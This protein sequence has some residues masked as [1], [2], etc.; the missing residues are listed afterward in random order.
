MRV[1]FMGSADVSCTMLEALLR[2]PGI[3]VAGVV[4]QPDR[5][6]GRHRS[7]T[8]CPGKRLAVER[9]LPVITPEKVN[10]EESLAQLAAWVPEVIVVVAYGQFLGKRLLA[11]PPH[12]CVNIHLSLLPRHRGAAPVQWAIAS[13]DAVSGVT[14]MLM[15]RGMDSGDILAQIDAPIRPDDT[16]ETLYQRLAPLGADLLVRTLADLAVG[17][18]QRTPQ[19]PSRVTFA[20][21]LKKEDGRINWSLPAEQIARRVRGFN[22]WPACY[23]TLPARLRTKDHAGRLKVLRAEVCVCV[24]ANTL[25]FGMLI[26]CNHDGPLIQTGQGGLR[27]TSVQLEGGKPLTGQAFLCGHA[28]WPNDRFGEP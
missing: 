11:L 7:L 23:T 15:D 1:V 20:A 24:S 21:K 9:G 12:G 3:R 14:A 8:P 10:S 2:A 26:D 18:A 17:R 5:P 25:P 28:L 6:A 19:D 27:L 4:A 16:A 13:G 22:P